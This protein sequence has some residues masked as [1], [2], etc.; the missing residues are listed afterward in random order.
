MSG[1]NDQEIIFDDGGLYLAA[2]HLG[3]GKIEVF[4][5][6]SDGTKFGTT[7]VYELAPVDKELLLTRV[8]LKLQDRPDGGLD[9]TGTT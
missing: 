2:R 8:G 1:A 6:W 4:V 9:I 5:N 3:N 7:K